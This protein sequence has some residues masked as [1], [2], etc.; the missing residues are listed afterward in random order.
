MSTEE[1][2]SR[3]GAASRNVSAIVGLISGCVGLLAGAGLTLLYLD[4]E[5]KTWQ[6]IKLAH[7]TELPDAMATIVY[8]HQDL[9]PTEIEQIKLALNLPDF[10]TFALASEIPVVPDLQ[11]VVRY[12]DEINLRYASNP[13]R[14]YLSSVDFNAVTGDKYGLWALER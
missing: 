13:S 3:L 11:N 2:V 6:S 1:T 5:I 7:Q 8:D 14:K 9:N 10:S 12:G 4:E